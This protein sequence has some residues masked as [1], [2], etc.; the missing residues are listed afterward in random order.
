MWQLY[1]IMVLRLP[2]CNLIL[3]YLGLCSTELIRA[4]S[5]VAMHRIVWFVCQAKVFKNVCVA[6]LQPE[7]LCSIYQYDDYCA[8]L[9]LSPLQSYRLHQFSFVC[10]IALVQLHYYTCQGIA[11]IEVNRISSIWVGLAVSH[12]SN[13]AIFGIL[14]SS[15][16]LVQYKRSG[17]DN[18][19]NIKII[20][21]GEMRVAEMK[22]YMLAQWIPAWFTLF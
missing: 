7:S 20:H 18:V 9:Y 14:P 10:R 4:Y 3:M 6:S 11:S 21:Q 16:Q 15:L 22:G 19:I 13:N 17:G 8:G 2:G 1:C 5:W 12:K